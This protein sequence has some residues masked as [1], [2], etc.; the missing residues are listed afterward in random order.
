MR[1]RP[2]NPESS[3]FY[4][5]SLGMTGM[6]HRAW[7]T[8]Q[9]SPAPMS[10]DTAPFLP[11]AKGPTQ[12]ETDHSCR[13]LASSDGHT[14]PCS[15]GRTTSLLKGHATSCPEKI[16]GG[17]CAVGAGPC[18][19]GGACAAGEGPVLPESHLLDR[20]A[21][22]VVPLRTSALSAGTWA[23]QGTAR[24]ARRPELAGRTHSGWGGNKACSKIRI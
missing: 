13:N 5:L 17:A 22:E 14:A 10:A 2:L 3:R 8:A 12:T 11:L 20:G 21:K 7:I 16:R 23:T 24:G 4:L 9:L 18:F 1:P 19:G 6:C 15:A